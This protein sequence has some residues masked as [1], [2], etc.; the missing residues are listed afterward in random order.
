M[1]IY[2]KG[3]MD[4]RKISFCLDYKIEM[5]RKEIDDNFSKIQEQFED[6]VNIDSI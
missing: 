4:I 3:N 6:V 2:R 1:I 5:N